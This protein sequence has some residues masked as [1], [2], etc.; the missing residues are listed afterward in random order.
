MGDEGEPE[1]PNPLTEAKQGSSRITPAI[2]FS[3]E[4]QTYHKHL[5]LG[6][7]DKL[8]NLSFPHII[9]SLLCLGSKIH[10]N[11]NL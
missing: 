8:R 3:Q 7:E 10:R 9:H 4:E 5:T 2:Q 11:K 1:L 6:I